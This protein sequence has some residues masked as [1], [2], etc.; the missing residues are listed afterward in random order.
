MNK[1]ESKTVKNKSIL[2]IFKEK[3]IMIIDLTNINNISI[4]GEELDGNIVSWLS[5]NEKFIERLIESYIRD[6]GW[7]FGGASELHLDIKQ[8]YRDHP[9]NLE[10]KYD[11]ENPSY[12]LLMAA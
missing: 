7:A 11:E 8:L 4:E 3:I 10:E 2:L 1:G 12:F 6:Y 5:M 9:Y